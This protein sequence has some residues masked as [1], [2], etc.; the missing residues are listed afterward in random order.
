VFV[1]PDQGGGD[2]VSIHLT[3]STSG[4]P[5]DAVIPTYDPSGFLNGGNAVSK[6]WIRTP[7][8]W[9]L[10]A[11][12]AEIT[13]TATHFVLSHTCV[14]GTPRTTTP[15]PKT[16]PPADSTPPRT[17]TPGDGDLPLTGTSLTGLLVA[18]MAL[19]VGGVVLLVLRRR[20]DGTA[21][22]R[23]DDGSNPL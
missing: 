14:P 18:G 13:G 3:F 21:G 4:G 23:P 10:T 6:A 5:V 15:P 20:R 7:A 12:T 17:T 16:T 22:P 8:G 1:L 19:V 9:T 2:F 11:A